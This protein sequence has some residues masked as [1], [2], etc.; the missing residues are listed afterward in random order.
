MSTDP[1]VIAKYRAG[2][3]ECAAEISRYLDTVNG[4]SPELKSRVM[5]YLGNSMAQFPVIPVYQGMA[6]GSYVQLQQQHGGYMHPLGHQ[7]IYTSRDFIHAQT[8][9][10]ERHQ[11]FTSPRSDVTSYSHERLVPSP[12]DSDSG[13]SDSSGITHDENGNYSHFNNNRSPQSLKIKTEQGMQFNI[14]RDQRNKTLYPR[15]DPNYPSPKRRCDFID[16]SRSPKRQRQ[17][18]NLNLDIK[19]VNLT[20]PQNVNVPTNANM[21]RPW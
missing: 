15:S 13:L 2:Y 1:N 7:N 16:E 5:N 6:P 21:W 11:H 10:N 12:C 19:P 4:G 20:I 8:L 3:N 9:D 14:P 18:D 17:S